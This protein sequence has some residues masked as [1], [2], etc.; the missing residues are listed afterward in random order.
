MDYQSTKQRNEIE[1]E[2]ERAEWLL[3]NIL[4]Q[5]VI[6]ALRN[7]GSF[8]SHDYQSAS[9]LFVS[10][11][12]FYDIYEEQFEGGQ[13]YGRVLN[14]F[15]ADIEELFFDSKFSKIDKIKTIGATY[16]VASGLQIDSNEQNSDDKSFV[17]FILFEM[18]C[19]NILESICKLIEFALAFQSTLH[20]F[21]EA[22]LYFALE[23]R[24]GLNFGPVTAAVIDTT[25]LFYDIWGDTVN[26]ASEMDLTGQIGRIQ[27]PE[28]VAL[29]LSGRYSFEYRGKIDIKG[30]GCMNTYFFELN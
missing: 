16:M 10:L 2:G 17:L 22:L 29:A 13:Y 11:A 14:E 15:Y 26:V 5:H 24:M 1:K 25:K 18:I 28:H 7:C 3:R 12:N 23:V 20:R 21:N 6:E 19:E 4:P 8:Y 27:V 30:K 9:V